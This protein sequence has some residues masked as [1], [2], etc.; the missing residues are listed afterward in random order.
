MLKYIFGDYL[1]EDQK[2]AELLETKGKKSSSILDE[3]LHD[4]WPLYELVDK[5]NQIYGYFDDWVVAVIDEKCENVVGYKVRP[6]EERHIETV[7]W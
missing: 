7:E 6:K 3:L 2:F 5:Y 1:A 4:Q